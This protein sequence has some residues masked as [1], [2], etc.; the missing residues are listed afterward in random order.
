MQITRAVRQLAALELVTTRKDGVQIVIE[1]T[2]DGK[3]LFEKA[4]PYMQSTVRKRFFVEKE[5]LPPRMPLAGLSA[6]S[7]FSMLN[8][9]DVTTYAFDG[10]TNELPGTD[11]L[12]DADAQAEIEVWRYPPTLLSRRDGLPDPLSLWVSLPD[13]DARVDIAK[14]ELLADVWGNG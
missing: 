8:P 12:V 2:T 9:P 11:T 4:R 7:E 10:K 14:D 5:N 13:G 1:G 6:L 3:A